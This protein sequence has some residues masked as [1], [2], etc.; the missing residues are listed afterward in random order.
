MDGSERYGL[1]SFAES[2]L[3]AVDRRRFACVGLFMGRGEVWR[4][5]AP[6]CDETVDLGLGPLLPL[7]RAGRSRY[8]LPTMLAKAVLFLRAVVRAARAIRRARLDVVH[9]HAYPVHLVAGLACRMAGVPCV[10]HWHGPFQH[11]GVARLATRVGFWCLADHVACISRF[12]L[13]TL[14]PQ[15]QRRASVVYNGVDTGR[16]AGGQQHG[17]LRRRIAV[18]EGTP[19]VGLFG[20]IM[21]RKGHEYFIRAAARVVQRSPDVRFVILGHEDEICRLRYG[22]ESRYRRLA[23]ELGVGRSVIFAG[24][25]P[26]AS[27]LMADCDIICMPTI[28]IGRDSGEGFGL[29]MAEAMAAGVPVIATSCGAP[30]E[31]IEDGV[32]G[33]L[34]PPRDERALAQAIG[35][36]FKD[37]DRRRRMGQAAQRRIQ[38]FFDV[39]RTARAMADVYCAAAR[40]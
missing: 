16:I 2:T 27:L 24:Y 4:R 33:I 7:S 3:K 12:V 37:D 28:P 10:W 39:G 18:P 22:F 21:E 25:I 23:E 14:P 26:D 35:A 19:L 31:V 36:L 6:A 29:V 9:V 11:G 40:R 32:S 8:H 5:L 38:D 30:P 15:V 34:V 20:A 13:E 1:L 17:V